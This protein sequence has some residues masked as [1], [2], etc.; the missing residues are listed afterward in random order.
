M[1][2]AMSPAAA[3]LLAGSKLSLAVF[4]QFGFVSS[5]EYL[6]S[7]YGQ[8][9][10]NG[11]T[12]TGVGELGTISTVTEDSATTAQGIT[13]S[14]SNIRP[15]LVTEVFTEVQQGLPAFL[16]LVFLS[17]QGVPIDSVG[18]FAGRMDDVVIAEGTDSDTVIISIENRLAD[19]QRA[20]FHRLTDQDQRLLYPTDDGFKFVQSLQDYNG[21]W[22]S[23]G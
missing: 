15:G 6:W 9:S 14:L 18:C 17:D 22:G 12:W 2:R 1:P 10:W 13:V 20:P 11:Q 7:G 8:I 21:S 19:L 23:N 16:W 4:G 5:T 3:A